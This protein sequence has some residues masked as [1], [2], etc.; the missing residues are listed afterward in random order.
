MGPHPGKGWGWGE[1][2]L[3]ER[4]T[5]ATPRGKKKTT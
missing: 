4:T 1:T 5:V 3:D 2:G